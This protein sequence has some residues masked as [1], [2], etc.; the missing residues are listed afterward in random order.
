MKPADGYSNKR[1]YGSGPIPCDVMII[2]EAP[3]AEEDKTGIPFYGSAG[4]ILNKNLKEAGLA[5]DDVFV[6]NTVPFRPPDNRKPSREE[7]RRTSKF[8]VEDFHT[9]RPKYVLLLGSTALD[10]LTDLPLGV[11]SN[12]GWIDPKHSA[13]PLYVKTF[14][15]YHPAYFL[16]NPKALPEFAEDLKEFAKVI[17]SGP[18]PETVSQL[19]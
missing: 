3:G 5:R 16:Y 13:F 11:T 2:G 9:V 14:V 4:K 10:F 1:V 17:L 12:R 8:L 18:N 19:N 7:F 6:T 15:T